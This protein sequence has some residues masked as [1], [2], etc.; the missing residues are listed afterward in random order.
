MFQELKDLDIYR[1]SEDL[2][3]RC[4]TVAGKWGDFAKDTVG[5][6]LTRAADSI[7]A[8]IAESFGR[9]HYRDRANFLYYARGSV[10]E[11]RFW[12]DRANRRN[13]I[14]AEEYATVVAVTDELL[15]KLNAYIKSKRGQ[16]AGTAN[17]APVPQS[18]G[19]LVT[20]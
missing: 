10:Y 14:D 8:N 4:W 20:Q 3:E 19:H 17:R 16:A 5:K 6:Q 12:L 9:Y 11:T 15:L 18:P 13:L 7:G 2:C 1:M